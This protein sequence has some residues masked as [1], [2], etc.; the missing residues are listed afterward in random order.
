ML[1]SSWWAMVEDLVEGLDH[2]LL[3]LLV[4]VGLAPVVAVE[5]LDPLE[6]ADG[7]AA[8]VAQD[9]RDHEHAALV[10]DLV[11]LG[12][13]RAV[14]GLGDDLGLDPLGVA[15]RDLVLERGRDQDVA[16]DLEDL[17]VADVLGAR[18]ALDGPVLL[19]PVDD[20]GD[21]EA[22]RVVDARRRVGDRDD[23]GA[24]LGDQRSR[25]SSRRCR[26][27]GPRRCTS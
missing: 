20:P 1:T 8:G 7:H 27:P 5:V 3:E 21:V 18:E 26:S 9:V 24:F 4:D 25:R 14:G 15:G 2:D 11:G 17:G 16:V 12:R 6:V 23:R 22:G 19:L 10:E 13:R